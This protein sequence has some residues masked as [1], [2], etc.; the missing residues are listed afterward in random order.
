MSWFK[1]KAP[2]GASK[3][4]KKIGVSCLIIPHGQASCKVLGILLIPPVSFI[5]GDM[6]FLLGISVASQES[7]VAL[8]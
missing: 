1:K 8:I 5:E 3:G 6:K 2:R 4:S 7:H